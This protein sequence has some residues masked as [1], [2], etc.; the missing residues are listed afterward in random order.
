MISGLSRPIQPA[1]MN[2]AHYGP[3]QLR[4]QRDALLDLVKKPDS[5]DV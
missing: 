1:T 3:D 5:P 2:G 4:E